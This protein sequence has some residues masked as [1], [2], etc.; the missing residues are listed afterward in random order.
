[1]TIGIGY[2]V[3]NRME[4]ILYGKMRNYRE[5]HDLWKQGQPLASPVKPESKG[6]SKKS[7]CDRKRHPEAYLGFDQ[8]PE[9]RPDSKSLV[10]AKMK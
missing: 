9:I 2:T 7:A 8:R 3:A 10:I 5:N 4:C 1:M 6:Q